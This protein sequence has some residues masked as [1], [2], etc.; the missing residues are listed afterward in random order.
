MALDLN[1]K[2][3]NSNT[4]TN[5]GAVEVTT[6]P[7]FSPNT[8]M[9]DFEST[10]PD[11]MSAADSASLSLST[12]GTIEFWIKFE[13]LPASGSEMF[14]ISKPGGFGIDYGV[15]FYNDAGAMELEGSI[16]NGV[17]KRDIFKWVFAFTTA[18]WY[19]IA[20]SFNSGNGSSTTFVAYIDTV[21][22]GNGVS[23]V[24]QDVVT[25]ADSA[26]ALLIG[27][28]SDNTAYL[29]GI[30]DE[31]RIWNTVRTGAQIS[32]N[33]NIELAGSESG[34][35]AYWPYNIIPSPAA[36]GPSVRGYKTLMGVGL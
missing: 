21:D 20:V 33:Y 25:I 32:S 26:N 3:A 18:T 27:K 31:I 15:T 29:D 24:S 13:S 9:A 8:S 16:S 22:K 10:D 7:P 36:G 23:I 30:I 19:H 1:D 2:T 35:A 17:D 14:A 34:L 6:S 12:T 11:F 5:S 4:L 28:K